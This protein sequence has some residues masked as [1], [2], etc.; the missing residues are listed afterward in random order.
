MAAE[1]RSEY[2]Q[3]MADK[4]R[5]KAEGCRLLPRPPEGGLTRW[6]ET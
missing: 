4:F 6:S 5:A 3:R 1:L 2:H